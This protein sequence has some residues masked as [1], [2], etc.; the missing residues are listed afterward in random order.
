MLQEASTGGNVRGTIM[1]ERMDDAD[2]SIMVTGTV[3]GKTFIENWP[4][5]WLE[6]TIQAHCFFF[7]DQMCFIYLPDS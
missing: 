2:D 5:S 3:S 4:P 1:F 6:A 7:I